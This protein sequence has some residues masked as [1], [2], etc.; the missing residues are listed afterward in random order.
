MAKRKMEIEVY[1][2]PSKK[3][4]TTKQTLKIVRSKPSSA[5]KGYVGTRGMYGR[6]SGPSGELKFFDTAIGSA[7]PT[8]A[9]VLA[10]GQLA[11]IPQGVT[12]STRVGRKCTIKSIQLNAMLRYVPATDATG[13]NSVTIC[14]VQD[15]QTNGAAATPANVYEPI[16]GTVGLTSSLRNIEYGDRFKILKRWDITLQPPAG[17]SGAY[18]NVERRVDLYKK[19]QIPLEFSSTTGAITELRSNNV[20][21]IGGASMNALATL[22]GTARLR[23]SDN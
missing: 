4:K 20:F 5:Q 6:F 16:Q 18:E 23:F 15:T 12:E 10:Q 17:V 8:T 2:G 14:L 1:D 11:L 19:C 7:I 21:L 3:S 9:A 13:V 22:Y